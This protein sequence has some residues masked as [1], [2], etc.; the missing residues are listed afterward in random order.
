MRQWTGAKHAAYLEELSVTQLATILVLGL[1]PGRTVMKD[2]PVSTGVGC[3]I[4]INAAAA[5]AAH[6]LPTTTGCNQTWL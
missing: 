2:L 4:I 1:K 6:S 3:T 5:A